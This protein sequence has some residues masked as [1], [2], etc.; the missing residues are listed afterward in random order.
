VVCPSSNSLLLL[1]NS[2]LLLGKSL[3]LFAK[4]LR[5]NSNS[6][7]RCRSSLRLAFA[8]L[9]LPFRSLRLALRSS[10]LPSSSLRPTLFLSH[11]AR[12][13]SRPRS[14]WSVLPHGLS[15]PAL[16]SL[17]L[18]SN[19]LRPRSGYWHPAK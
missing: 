10:R 9:R 5:L 6:F 3:L 17:L 15:R 8:P 4:S 7:R 18:C 11:A 19:W 2:L 1:T 13:L 16:G 14:K 12:L